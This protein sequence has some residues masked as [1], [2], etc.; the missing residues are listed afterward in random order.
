M[1]RLE[2]LCCASHSFCA[3][4]QQQLQSGELVRV[5]DT[6][7]IEKRR[8][9]QQQ[10]CADRVSLASECHYRVA[11][12]RSER[13][14]ALTLQ[15]GKSTSSVLRDTLAL[16]RFNRSL[17]LFST[18]LCQLLDSLPTWL[19]RNRKRNRNRNETCNCVV[20]ESDQLL[21]CSDG[22]AHMLDTIRALLARLF[23]ALVELFARCHC[24]ERAPAACE[25]FESTLLHSIVALAT[26]L[27][28]VGLR[29]DHSM[30]FTLALGV[31]DA[32]LARHVA[33]AASSIR[34]PCAEAQWSDA[35]FDHF[36]TSARRALF[37][38]DAHSTRTRL[39]L[40][41]RLPH[42]AFARAACSAGAARAHELLGGYLARAADE[43]I[44][45]DELLRAAL[46][47]A[48]RALQCVVAARR[49]LITEPVFD[50]LLVDAATRVRRHRPCWPLLVG[51]PCEH[52]SGDAAASSLLRVVL[53][54]RADAPL[55]ACVDVVDASDRDGATHLLG[56]ATHLAMTRGGSLVG[57]AIDALCAL[58][59]AQR[60]LEQPLVRPLI[61]AVATLLDAHPRAAIEALVRQLAAVDREQLEL[62]VYMCGS[63]R[64]VQVAPLDGDELL[65]RI[66]SWLREWPL[67]ADSAALGRD[68]LARLLIERVLDAAALD[69]RAH[70]TLLLAVVDALHWHLIGD[71]RLPFYASTAAREERR[72]RLAWMTRWALRCRPGAM[73]S[74][75]GTERVL[76]QL[77][78]LAQQLWP[79]AAAVAARVRLQCSPRRFEMAADLSVL[80]AH[81][82]RH[83][84]AADAYFLSLL[85][86]LPALVSDNMPLH[87]VSLWQQE[88]PIADR[89]ATARWPSFD[90]DGDPLLSR[91]RAVVGMHVVDERAAFIVYPMARYWLA[92]MMTHDWRAHD[93][94][95]LRVLDWLAMLDVHFGTATLFDMI[96]GAMTL[97]SSSLAAASSSSSSSSSSLWLRWWSS[98]ARAT[99]AGDDEPTTLAQLIVEL[100]GNVKLLRAAPWFFCEA[101]RRVAPGNADVWQ[102]CAVTL[103]RVDAAVAP[104]YWQYLF[105]ALLDARSQAMFAQ[106]PASVNVVRDSLGALAE[107][108]R[109]RPLAESSATLRLLDA[110]RAW[111]PLGIDCALVG[112]RGHE[113]ALQRFGEQ[114]RAVAMPSLVASLVV[115]GGGGDDDNGGAASPWVQWLD[116]SASLRANALSTLDTLR[117]TW[118]KRSAVAP[119]APIAHAAD[120]EAEEP[121]IHECQCDDL[122]SLESVRALLAPLNVAPL[123]DDESLVGVVGGS[124]GEHARVVCALHDGALALN[125]RYVD[126]LRQL[127]RNTDEPKRVVKCCWRGTRCAGAA[128]F[129]F[130]SASRVEVVEA[131]RDE[132][133][134][135]R[136]Q[137]DALW[138]RFKAALRDADALCRLMAR[139]EL[140]V[141]AAVARGDE[142]C[143]RLFFAW[144][145]AF[146]GS[147]ALRRQPA[148]NSFV[149]SLLVTLASRSLAATSRGN[150]ALFGAMMRR[151]AQLEQRVALLASVFEPQRLEPASLLL[152]CYASL[153][154]DAYRSTVLR[155]V[156]PRFDLA[157]WSARAS[158]DER[159]S[160]FALLLDAL[161]RR[162]DE[163]DRAVWQLLVEHVEALGVLERA[164][165]VEASGTVDALLVASELYGVSDGTGALDERV[166][167]AVLRGASPQAFDALC[168]ALLHRARLPFDRR[169]YAY[170]RVVAQLAAERFAGRAR[171]VDVLE[172]WLVSASDDCVP[173]ALQLVESIPW[174]AN[175]DGALPLNGDAMWRLAMAVGDEPRLADALVDAPDASLWH[176]WRPC[177]CALGELAAQ[178]AADRSFAL[179][180]CSRLDW[181]S[182]LLLGCYDCDESMLLAAVLVQWSAHSD[183][184]AQL[185][186]DA[187]DFAHRLDTIAPVLDA[188]STVPLAALTALDGTTPV[189]RRDASLAKMTELMRATTDDDA[190]RMR[191]C[192][193]R[194]A[195]ASHWMSEAQMDALLVGGSVVP[196][197][198]G[199][200]LSALR[201]ACE[202]SAHERL[203]VGVLLASRRVPSIAQLV[204]LAEMALNALCVAKAAL[205]SSTLIDTLAARVCV[206][207]IDEARD[208]FVSLALKR[209]AVLTLHTVYVR[210]ESKRRAGLMLRTLFSWLQVLHPRAERQRLLLLLWRDTVEQLA[211]GLAGNRARRELYRRFTHYVRAITERGAQ[212]RSL[213]SAAIG[214]VASS[215]SSSSSSSDADAHPAPL[216]LAAHM[217]AIFLDAQLRDRGDD[218]FSIYEPPEAWT[219]AGIDELYALRS[220]STDY[221]ALGDSIE[222]FQ[223]WLLLSK[224][225]PQL[226]RSLCDA[227][228]LFDSI[229]FQLQFL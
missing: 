45:G 18:A 43:R 135:N 69:E 57:D 115:G 144:L 9:E 63:L 33:L 96:D 177:A 24:H 125:K 190:D 165:D 22:A 90:D 78:A 221:A 12:L 19:H 116:E 108:M 211:I 81:W 50:A 67:G 127:Y 201:D 188:R 15:L 210:A 178:L 223:H 68:T 111:L 71:G 136:S 157:A 79:C 25:R 58:L 196:W 207:E 17:I 6:W 147:A 161:R 152:E 109:A 160:C 132:L 54:A 219:F 194:V 94:A 121:P 143:E 192:L 48:V 193:A 224:S 36:L 218:S 195:L 208:E 16:T 26:P 213:V 228:L 37:D 215:S 179:A 21:L 120:N 28:S 20:V 95:V 198:F 156:L 49:R 30:L 97:P 131:R 169:A 189:Q 75:V 34:F 130:D 145:P 141:S 65:E 176:C 122:P 46:G 212:R 3:Q 99:D 129:Y 105:V 23:R 85:T 150:A 134:A 73:D 153:V 154:G 27:L 13:L 197:R 229:L 72:E 172:P 170:A 217:L 77:E 139:I 142:L 4:H 137:F 1:Q 42:E 113:A 186:C 89:A 180:L 199:D 35:A 171:L 91:L 227:S 166:W 114:V 104:L 148:I 83:S 203:A 183:V 93:G 11:T 56:A 162:R 226:C 181:P 101:L 51:L 14:H 47:A 64:R 126:A 200:D 107:R 167:H 146:D 87:L 102:R 173:L 100:S 66:G 41:Q 175:N 220:F 168:S 52:A 31:P 204:A 149:S 60:S 206:P 164:D 151:D 117:R 209:H 159:A 32:L 55:L 138:R 222:S 44:D 59:F 123:D 119:S 112:A 39:R 182:L 29:R 187:A 202:S 158:I 74:V 185:L 92:E 40:W 62:A 53:C 88:Q 80:A 214:F 70:R 103:S 10:M 110:M 5:N 124:L 76:G 84:A 98:S 163:D 106:H 205:T 2:A 191:A 118:L 7:A 38:A 86:R 82:H 155:R 174:A 225:T 8:V 184:P 133:L 61:D 140:S 216:R 128:S